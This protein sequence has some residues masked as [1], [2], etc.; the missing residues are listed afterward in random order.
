MSADLPFE[1]PSC[2]AR[3]GFGSDAVLLGIV[4]SLPF[5]RQMTPCC[6]ALIT[7]TLDRDPLTLT[8][9]EWEMP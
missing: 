3:F 8:I 6:G 7:G 5:E 2:G 4:S 1:C 9:E